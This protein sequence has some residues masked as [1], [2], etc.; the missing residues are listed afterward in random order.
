MFEDSTFESNGRI[1]TRSRFW[2]IAT[3]SFNGAILLALILIPLIYPEALQR[4]GIA[5]L[6]AVP[7]LE[8][9]PQPKTQPPANAPRIDTE[10]TDRGIIAP[11]KIPIGIFIPT[12]QEPPTNVN[13][14]TWDPGGNGSSDTGRIFPGHTSEPIVRQAVTGPVAVSSGVVEALQ[15]RRT[16]P[17][18]PSIPR[19]AGIR[20]TVTL[21]ATISKNGTIENLRVVSGPV[22]LQQAALDA[23][24]T[25]AYKPYLLDGQPVEVETTVHV[26]FSLGR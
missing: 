8:T 6:M 1:H 7:P 17:V 22:M 18:Y 10:T 19:A 14:A 16:V 4:Q 2:M 12:V 26:V 25:W 9:P 23:V 13:V 11:P 20:G 5:Y 15:L 3:L 24:K 21:Q